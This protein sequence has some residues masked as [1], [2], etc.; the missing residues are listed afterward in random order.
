MPDGI[1]V[2]CSPVPVYEGRHKQDKSA[3]GLMEIGH[4]HI[5][6]A[7]FEA[8]HDDDACTGYKAVFAAAVQI[9]IPPA[10]CMRFSPAFGG[11]V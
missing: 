5:H 1:V 7:E 9:D 10:G 3:F 11:I 4:Q 2:N 8:G 6:N